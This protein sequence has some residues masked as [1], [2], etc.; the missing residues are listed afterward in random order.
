MAKI[1]RLGWADGLSF[2]S[3][4]LRIGVRVNDP[5]LMGRVL[6]LLPPGWKPSRY[7]E[8][9]QLYSLR[10]GGASRAANVRRLHL[11]YTGPNR[12]GRMA[13]LEALLEQFERDLHTYTATW[14]PRRLFVHAGVVGWRGRAIVLPGNSYTGKTSLIAA[15]VRAGATY[16][17]DEYAVFDREG[18][19][20]P[21]ARPLQIRESL[22][23]PPRRCSPGELGGRSGRKPLPVGM[24]AVAEYRSGA[25]WQP[26]QLSP[27]MG[28]QELLTHSLQARHRT[29]VTLA[30]LTRVVP[31]ALILKGRRGEAEQVAEALLRRLE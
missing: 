15:L 1:N 10:Q 18:R 13:D 29:A 22:D 30:T 2:I 31:H 11:M 3:H 16:Y 6:P 23:G 9:G 20:H 4:G 26:R 25:R 5:E 19:V 28:L 24:I 7:A 14:A 12:T 17:S 27:G 21:F 8:V